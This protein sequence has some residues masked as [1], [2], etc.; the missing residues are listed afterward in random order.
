[1]KTVTPN[2]TR[3]HHQFRSECLEKQ[4]WPSEGGSGVTVPN[5]P[6]DERG[7]SGAASPETLAD[8]GW[9]IPFSGPTAGTH[10]DP[11]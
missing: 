2:E 1:M 7:V 5:T 3:S 4:K 6:G 11:S 10:V 8:P 9:V